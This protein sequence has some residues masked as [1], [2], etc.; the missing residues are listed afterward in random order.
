M[1][2]L[3]M[4]SSQPASSRPADPLDP[5]RL[6]VQPT[7]SD[8]TAAARQRLGD[9]NARLGEVIATYDEAEVAAVAAGVLAKAAQTSLIE[10]QAVATAAAAR[11]E[12]D[13]ALLISV[14]TEAYTTS[15]VGAFGMLF[16]AETDQDLLTGMMMLQEMGAAQVATVERAERSRDR[17]RDA[18]AAVAEAEEHAREKLAMSKAAVAEAEEARG[19]VLA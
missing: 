11:Y 13:R 8:A 4:M 5:E 19:H 3:V 18:A 6:V 7:D 16:S 17:L 14:I 2:L 9:I 12:K 1:G 10:A 15:S